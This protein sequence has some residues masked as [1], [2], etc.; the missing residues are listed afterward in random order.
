MALTFAFGYG[1][2]TEILNSVNRFISRYPGRC[3]EQEDLEK[4]LY[5]PNMNDVDLLIRTGGD[6][7]VSNFLLWKIAYAE[8]FFTKTQ[9]P[10]FTAEE[11][12]DILSARPWTGKGGLVLCPRD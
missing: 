1:G 5:S 3:M 8:L 12:R 2:R 7:R 4:N 9:W 11:F 6:Q 10:D